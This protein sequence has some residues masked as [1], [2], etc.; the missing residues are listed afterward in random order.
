[1]EIKTDSP[2]LS[3]HFEAHSAQ[4]ILNNPARHNIIDAQSWAAL[5]GLFA[6]LAALPD[7]RLIILRGAGDKAFCAGAD[8]TQLPDKAHADDAHITDGFAAIA[9]CPVPSVA[10][11]NG[12]CIGGGVGLALCCDLRIARADSRFLIPSGRL[13]IAYPI[14]VTHRLAELIGPAKAKEMFFTGQSY[15][16]QAALDMGLVNRLIAPD[17]FES[18]LIHISEQICA[19]APLSLRASKYIID[20]GAAGDFAGMNTQVRICAQSADHAEGKQAFLEKR[21]P[22]FTG[23]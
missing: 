2:F 7:I 3:A 1:M 10:A 16:A 6:Q 4:V 23:K 17:A 21:A 8:V 13:G 22:H 9:A 18:E 11:I 20:Q 12:L 19:Q 14:R 5:P 15:N